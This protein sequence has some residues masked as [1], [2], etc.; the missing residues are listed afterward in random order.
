MTLRTGDAERRLAPPNVTGSG[1]AGEP[2]TQTGA[3]APPT[4]TGSGAAGEPVTQTGA[5]APPNVTGSITLVGAG[6]GDPD[7]V[8]LRAELLL[9]GAATVVFD[10]GIASL[11]A[12]FAPGATVVTVPDRA[13]AVD[14]LLAAAAA[15]RPVVR[16]YTG[17]PWLHPAYGSESGALGAAGIPFEAV[18]GVAT[19]FALPALAG[20]AVHVRHLAMI[21][22]I[23]DFGDGHA[24]TTTDPSRTLVLV[25][26]DLAAARAA[27]APAT[28]AL[29]LATAGNGGGLLVS[30]AVV[31]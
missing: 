9:A 22:T 2:V 18:A 17:D 19:E 26:D 11:V 5:L 4:V 10:V 31:R 29:A 27:C 24:P 30:G 8:T 25:A 23:A 15:D 6:P 20:V 16:L 14:V 7:L 13:P 3:L 28:A 21:C 12:T 1:A